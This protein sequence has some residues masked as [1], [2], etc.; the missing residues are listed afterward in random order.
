MSTNDY[1]TGTP[2]SSSYWTLSVW[3]GSL[4]NGFVDYYA[5]CYFGTVFRPGYVGI[6]NEV[7]Y[8]MNRFTRATFVG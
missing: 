7:K 8:F 3:D 5:N 4:Q 6:L 1:L 2:F